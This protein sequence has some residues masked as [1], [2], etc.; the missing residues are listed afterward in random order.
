MKKVF[1]LLM[2]LA[3]LATPLTAFGATGVTYTSGFNLQNLGTTTANIVVD[4]YNQDGTVAYS[5]PDTIPAQQMKIYFPLSGVPANFNGSAVVSS[6]Q[7]VAAITNVLGN[8]G[9]RGDSYAGAAAG[10]TTISLPLVMKGNYNN[11]TWFNVQNTGGSDATVTVA[12]APGTCT[13]TKTV[14][15]GAA[16]TFDQSANACLGTKF[17]GAAKVTS[18]QPV[19]VVVMEVGTYNLL[20]YAGFTSAAQKPVMPL[21]MSNNYGNFT[22][23]S[24][25]NTGSSDTTV[26]VSYTPAAGQPG[27]A[28]TESH[29]VPAGQSLTFGY[30]TMPAG[31]GPKFVGS[32]VVT[33]NSA[34]Q[35]LAVIVNQLNNNGNASAYNA[36]DPAKATAHVSLPLVM[37]RNYGLYTGISIVN[38]GTQ[39]T[40]V[41]CTFSNT[42]YQIQG[43]LAVGGSI[44]EV[45]LNK[46]AAGY[47]GGGTCTATGGDQKISAIV[48]QVKSAPVNNDVLFTYPGFNY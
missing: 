36:F 39:A 48:N 34:N 15:A 25:M 24:I 44:T 1:V 33:G 11:D 42:S 4:F 7:Q 22:G 37:D 3:L 20:S 30:P 10:G 46:I 6:D 32:G 8:N 40:N 21:I 16:A 13:E 2:A 45:Q 14:K 28:C 18:T 17:L 19:A 26:D 38:M 29:L 47:T 27:T 35:P 9:Q 41:T 43:A 12:Y 31:C 23:A 5:L